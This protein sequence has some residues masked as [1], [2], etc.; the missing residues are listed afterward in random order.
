MTVQRVLFGYFPRSLDVSTG[1]VTIS[2]LADLRD[3]VARVE[4]DDGVDGKWIYAPRQRVVSFGGRVSERPYPSRVFGLPKTHAI[5]HARPDGEDHLTFDLWALSFLTGTRLTATEAGFVDATPI[6]EGE[7]VDFVLRNDLTD[8]LGLAETFWAAHCN[9]PKRAK[10]FAG[11]VHGL[12]LA[13][14]PLSLQYE[15]FLHLYAAL[16]ACF[17]LAL[18]VHGGAARMPHARRVSWMCDLFGIAMPEWAT[19]KSANN[20]EI[21]ALRNG[22]V[23]EALY[24][25]Q[26]LGFALHGVGTAGN[27]MLEMQ[28]LICRL[29]VALLGSG[30]AQYVTSPVTTRQMHGLTLVVS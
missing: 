13:Q 27:L 6:K 26:P 16:D 1:P 20:T 21:A 22:T 8:A 9:A 5:E 11:A 2:S 14:N 18:S 10:L 17:A 7:L 30:R 12:F 24:L 4:Q 23:H 15:Q 19:A 25:G 29:L 28:A 3:S